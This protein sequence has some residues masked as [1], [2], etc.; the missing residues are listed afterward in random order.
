MGADMLDE[1]RLRR[2][3]RALGD[4][5]WSAEALAHATGMRPDTARR[6]VAGKR[7]V[8]DWLLGWLEQLAQAHRAIPLPPRRG[9]GEP[10]E[11]DSAA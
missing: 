5:H 11:P 4:I 3:R 1:D 7:L 6:I 9:L 8:P 2:L 10:G